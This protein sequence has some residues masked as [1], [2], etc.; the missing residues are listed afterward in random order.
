MME[1]VIVIGGSGSGKST[2]ARKLHMMTGLPLYHLDFLFWKPDKTHV[3]REV[4]D[5]R[6][7]VILGYEKFIIDGEYGRTLRKRIERSD[8]VFF[9]D[10]P[11]AERLEGARSRIGTSREDMP[12]TE[13][14]FDPDFENYIRS[15][16]T[17]IRPGILD[18]LSAYPE[19]NVITFRCRRD[20]DRYLD[21]I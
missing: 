10:I 4:F 8:T 20:A 18:M 17:E 9:F 6:L 7:D 15:Y 5:R 14:E 3:S 2:F 11:L 21:A 16:G 1:K 13:T 19:K 12:W